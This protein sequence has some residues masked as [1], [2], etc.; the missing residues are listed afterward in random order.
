MIGVNYL[1]SK[2]HI[3]FVIGGSNKSLRIWFE[4]TIIP[5]NMATE[6]K[7]GPAYVISDI[8]KIDAIAIG[9]S[10][11]QIVWQR[12]DVIAKAS[13]EMEAYY[14]ADTEMTQYWAEV[15]QELRGEIDWEGGV[16]SRIR[17]ES[18]LTKLDDLRVQVPEWQ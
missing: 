3:G 6:N 8:E 15:R 7:N 5:Q 10:G 12:G 18:L 17:E 14:R 2:R 13:E 1:H 11:D 4:T 16:E 9:K